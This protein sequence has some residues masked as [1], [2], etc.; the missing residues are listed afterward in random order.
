MPYHVEADWHL[1]DTCNYRCSYCFFPPRILGSKLRVFADA[2]AW[3]QGFDATGYSWLIHITG[4]EPS[5]YPDFVNL[6]EGLTRRHYISVNSN[7]SSR[8]FEDFVDRVDPSRVS[9]INAGLHLEERE[10][11]SGNAVFLG[12]VDLLRSKRF[13]VV[14]S[15]VASP[16]ALERFEE[17]VELLAPIGA[18]PVPKLLRGNYQGKKYPGAYTELDKERFREYARVA[19]AHYQPMLGG[20]A[21]R[22]TIDMFHDDDFLDAVPSFLGQSCEAGR[23]FVRIDSNGDIFRCGTSDSIGNVLN[24]VFER[25]AGPAPCDTRYCFY[26]CRKYAAPRQAAAARL[27]A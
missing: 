23:L 22:P 25:S 6:C 13:R 4:G 5:I 11:R 20:D 12:N 24:S 3:C 2:E 1:L 27:P 26:F 8:I 17:A 16:R 7:L 21:E 10:R 14:I 18:Y 15:L 19:R 9:F